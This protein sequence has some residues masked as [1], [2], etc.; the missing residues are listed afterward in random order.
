MY[1]VTL[2]ASN[3]NGDGSKT[4]EDMI[5]AEGIQLN[6]SEDFESGSSSSFQ[7]M[8]NSLAK[9]SIDGRASTPASDFGLHFQGGGQIGGWS[10][11]PTNTT[12]D[13]AWNT[14]TDYHGFA[15]NCNVDATGVQGVSLLLDLRQTYSIGPKYSWFRVLVNDEP[16]LDAN[17][18]ENFNPET[19]TDPF[20]TRSFDLSSHGNSMFSLT[21][22][23]A[24]YLLDGYYTEGD[25]VFVDNVLIS[26]NTAVDDSNPSTAGV[27]TYP[28]PVKDIFNFSAHGTGGELTVKV[29]NTQGRIVYLENIKYQEGH[30]EQLKLN[31]LPAGVYV[32]QLAGEKGVATK[33]FIKQ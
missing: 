14:N 31:H 7:L 23:S 21:M 27:L 5:Y 24:C 13:Q 29:I 17:G 25:N 2:T 11:G 19:N 8:A 26:N 28:N 6:F 15:S 9:V 33:K 4:M 22:Q 30:S 20:V 1:T 12:P 3:A 18:M 32:L 10:G 16:V